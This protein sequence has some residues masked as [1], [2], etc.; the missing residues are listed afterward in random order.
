M[1]KL[2]FIVPVAVFLIS[3]SGCGQV[4][5][6][7]A[8]LKTSFGKISSSVLAP[9]LYWVNPIGVALHRYSLRDTR[10]DVNMNAYTKDMQQADF[11][12]SVIYAV[13]KT[14]VVD[15]HTKWGMDYA[16]TIIE[17]IVQASLK[18]VVG[19]WEADKLVNGREEATKAVMDK[20]MLAMHETPI[21]VKGL[22]ILNIDYSDVFEKAIEA[23]QVAAQSALEAKNKTMQVEEEAKQT[24]VKAKAEAEAIQIRAKALAE[25]KDVIMLN[26]IEK[27]DGKAPQTLS[28]G[29]EAATMLMPSSGSASSTAPSARIRR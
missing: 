5:T 28:L 3:I 15:L 18:D 1:K 23:K 12:I 22:A 16:R 9:G 8:G 21:L 14:K 11:Q 29:G 6:G 20:V 27:W 4:D 7:D 19:Q 25:N 2:L 26:L 10:Y 24:I 17:P 13:N